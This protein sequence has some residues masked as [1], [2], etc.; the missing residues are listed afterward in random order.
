MLVL[1][2]LIQR[3]SWLK[4]KLGVF[5]VHAVPKLFELNKKTA[6]MFFNNFKKHIGKSTLIYGRNEDGRKLILKTR[7]FHLKYLLNSTSK[8]QVV[9]K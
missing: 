5:N 1:R 9:W 2:Y 6:N 7:L 8:N 3:D 4:G